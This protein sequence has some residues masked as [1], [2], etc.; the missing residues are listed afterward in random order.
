MDLQTIKRVGIRAAYKAGR[1]L[2]DHFDKPL[3]VKKKGIIDLVTQ[4]DIAS[5]KAI[6]A[7]IKEVFPDHAILA[8]ESGAAAGNDHDRWIIDP[9]DGTTNFAHHLPIFAVSIAYTRD[10]V[11]LMG[12]VFNPANG[13]LFTAVHGQGASLNDLPIQVSSVKTLEDSL[14]VTGFPYTIRTTSP[15][16]PVSRFTRCLTA[17]QGVRRLGSAALDLCF[18][19][20]GRFEGFWEEKLK[21]WDTAAGMLMVQEAGGRVT[22]YKDRAY[23]VEDQQILAT[24][25]LIHSEMVQLLNLEDGA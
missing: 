7:T 10:D 16:E 25:A 17:S 22:D 24:N 19:A 13:E 11:P 8:E 4:A 18:V 6:V 2:I 20:C 21:P 15:A 9:L 23:H 1:I 3:Q 14:L 5:E 12:I